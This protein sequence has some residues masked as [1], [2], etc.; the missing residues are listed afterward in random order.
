M[1]SSVTFAPSILS[2]RI[3]LLKFIT[4]LGMLCLSLATTARCHHGRDFIT[5]Q[6]AAIPG[7]LNA[8][9]SAG[10]EW[11]REGNS[12]EYSTEPSL[13][14]GVLP[15]LALGYSSAFTDSGNGL[16]SSA[17]T[18]Q[19]VLRLTPEDWPNGLRAGLWLGYEFA[20]GGGHSHASGA[21]HVHSGG[22]G[23]DAGAPSMHEHAQPQEQALGT[24]RHG[25][26]GLY[27]RLI[28]ERNLGANTRALLNLVQFASADGGKPGFGY[29]LGLRHEWS[30][31]F[32]TGLEFSGDF[33]RR[34]SAHQVL[35]TGMVSVRQGL[36][37]R[38]GVGGGMTRA[39]PD[40]TLHSS[41]LWR[42]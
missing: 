12:N 26:S 6:D 30:H 40:F 28:V 15:M 16:Q 1:M 19:M 23:P 35:L 38:L 37:L 2:L 11:S 9:L 18:P 29:G 32:T 36:S 17:I 14:L 20:Q 8:I 10:Y 39:A 25:E 41:L 3:G 42:F 4:A 5:L 21:T 22:S 27:S 31:N 13:F 33:Q 34:Q 24:H 7:R